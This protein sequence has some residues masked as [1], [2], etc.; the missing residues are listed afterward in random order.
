VR[1]GGTQ[2]ARGLAAAVEESSRD[3]YLASEAPVVYVGSGVPEW[4]R[5]LVGEG[6]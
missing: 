4:V 3:D 5:I 1:L 6:R 2:L